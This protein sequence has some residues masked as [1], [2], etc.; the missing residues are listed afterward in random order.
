MCVIDAN[1]CDSSNLQHAGRRGEEIQH[2]NPLYLGVKR[3]YRDMGRSDVK[4]IVDIRIND[5]FCG[6]GKFG[7]VRVWEWV[8]PSRVRN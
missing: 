4:G 5:T 3:D 2:R 6:G 7:Q 8:R 1:V